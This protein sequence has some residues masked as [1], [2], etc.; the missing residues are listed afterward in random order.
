MINKIYTALL[1]VV[2]V[3]MIWPTIVWLTVQVVKL[4]S[5]IIHKIKYETRKQKP[6]VV[7]YPDGRTD[8]V[9]NL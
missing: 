1:C 6:V 7:V 5:Y 3:V 2:L 8:Y 9:G 4:I